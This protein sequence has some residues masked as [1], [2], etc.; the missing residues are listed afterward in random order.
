LPTANAID[1]VSTDWIIIEDDVL[2]P[3][4]TP[5]ASWSFEDLS[6]LAIADVNDGVSGI[7]LGLFGNITPVEGPS[8]TNKAVRVPLGGDNYLKVYHGMLES[9]KTYATV[10]TIMVRFRMPDLNGWH[11][12]LQTDITPA[13]DGD[14]FVRDNGNIGVG[15]LGYVGPALEAG[16]WY[17]LI[18]T[19]QNN[20]FYSYVNGIMYHN[21]VS[22]SNERFNLQEAFLISQ[23]ESNEDHDIDIAEI[24]VWKEPLTETQ[25][26]LIEIEQRNK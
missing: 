10:W 14:F 6:N 24:A 12:I 20:S 19:R 23:D 26:I 5:F 9:G 17:C 22:S 15:A 11:T 4:I 1:T 3:S 8:S 2:K 16:Q 25:R 18:M 13:G 7:P 21:N